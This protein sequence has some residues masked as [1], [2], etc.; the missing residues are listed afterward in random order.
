MT[1]NIYTR[2]FKKVD[3]VMGEVFGISS[4]ISVVFYLM[5]KDYNAWILERENVGEERQ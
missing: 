1:T 2:H 3:S 5:Y 4:L